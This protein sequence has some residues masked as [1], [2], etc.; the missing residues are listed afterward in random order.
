MVP[1]YRFRQQQAVHAFAAHK[2][3]V[4]MEVASP[5]LVE[6]PAWVTARQEAFDLF[7]GAFERI[8]E[9]SK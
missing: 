2:A 7:L 5:E 3:L 4:L 6:N 1:T 8:P 9:T